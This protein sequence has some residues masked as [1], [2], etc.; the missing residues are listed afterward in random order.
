VE[1]P[2]GHEEVIFQTGQPWGGE[3]VHDIEIR[4]YH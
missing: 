1:N 3:E 4:A 2:Y